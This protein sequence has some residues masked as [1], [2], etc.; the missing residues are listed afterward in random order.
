MDKIEELRCM[1]INIEDEINYLT[2]QL[3]K[4]REKLRNEINKRNYLTMEAVK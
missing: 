4:A 3:K 1:V 2:D